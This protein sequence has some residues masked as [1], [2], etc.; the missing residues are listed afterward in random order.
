MKD[1]LEFIGIVL[2]CVLLAV[3]AAALCVAVL[4]APWLAIGA[5]V[6]WVITAVR[7]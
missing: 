3:G 2:L 4:A 6:V 1:N 7:G 5:A